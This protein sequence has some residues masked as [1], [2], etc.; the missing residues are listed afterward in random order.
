VDTLKDVEDG[1]NRVVRIISDLR[2]FTRTTNETNQIFELKP[3]AEKTMRFFAHEWKAGIQHETDVP[4][5]LEMR[6]DPNHIVQVLVNLIQNAIDAMRTKTYPEGESP[7]IR[8]TG[9]NAGSYVQIIVRDNGPGV[10]Q[11]IRNQIFDPFFTTKDV[12]AG[13]GLGLAIC[14][15]VIE[16]HEGRIDVRS[17][18][19]SYTEFVLEFPS[20]DAIVANH[21][22]PIP[23]HP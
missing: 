18:P 12:G 3:L 9:K 21:N 1:V 20:P 10:P 16:E 15:R 8:I 17:E 5:G 6:G 19:G 7:C 23:G 11:E 13:M 22:I 4:E 2:G 14:H